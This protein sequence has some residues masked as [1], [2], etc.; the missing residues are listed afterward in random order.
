MGQP[1]VFPTGTTIYKP[2]E[3]WNGYTLYNAHNLGAMLVD[4]NGK[5]VRHWQNFQGFPNKIL[6]NGDIMGHFGNRSGKFGFQDGLQLVQV[7]WEGNV[8]WKFDKGEYIEDPGE[9]PQW[10]ARCHHDYQREGNPVGY[11]TPELNAKTD[12]GNTLILSH[13][14][15]VNSKISEKTLLDDCIYEVDWTGKIIWEWYC[16][17]HFDELGFTEQMKTVLF[18]DPNM[19]SIGEG[20]GDWVHINCMSMLG[21]NKWYEAGDSRFHPDNII[22][23]CRE[24]NILFIIDKKTGELCWK[25]GPDYSDPELSHIGAIIGQHHTHMIPKGLPGEGNIL[26]FDNGGWA[27]YGFPNEQS[28]FGEKSARRDYSRVL[29]INPITLDLEWQYTKCTFGVPY[30]VGSH[31]FYSELVSSAQRLE[32]G[33][34]L[35]C[36]GTEGRFLEVTKNHEVVWEFVNPYIGPGN[37]YRA[38]RIPYEW[39]PTEKPEEVPVL[40]IDNTELRLDGAAPKKMENVFIINGTFEQ[41]TA[42]K[43]TSLMEAQKINALKLPKLFAIDSK[44]IKE[45]TSDKVDLL[46]LNASKAVIVFGA[47]RCENSRVFYQKISGSNK[48]REEEPVYW[49]DVDKYPKFADE[50]EI[51]VTPT[52]KIVEKNEVVKTFVGVSSADF[53]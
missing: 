37:V 10:M 20:M 33:N 36:E 34:T 11:Y 40:P 51:S 31:H 46:K 30:P 28:T 27:G 2:E 22:C 16:H 35:I 41:P 39:I 13:K 24:A 18:R 50:Y 4:M 47:L 21:P 52:T 9:T 5:I 49:V 45:I 1:S 8:V 15:V 32:N 42:P 19:M 14:N 23:D 43:A 29:E 26:V 7:D 25:L 6:P 12:S 17:E 53:L 44:R 3:C 38:Y 48:V